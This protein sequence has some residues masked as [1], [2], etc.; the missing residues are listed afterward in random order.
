MR[1]LVALVLMS[2]LVALSLKGNANAQI[3][4][5]AQ[6]RFAESAVVE[7]LRFRQGDLASLM[8]SKRLFTAAGWADFVKRLAG[9]VDTQGAPSFTSSFV[10]S[11]S[12]IASTEDGDSRIVT[13][14]GVLKHEIRHPQGGAS[15]V[16]YRA[17]IDL[18][19]SPSPFKIELLQQRTCGGSR[20]MASCR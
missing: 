7:A 2:L 9:H 19:V 3:N 15:A 10:P 5:D 11:A 14:P 18:R 12:A 17:E 8:D 20:T 13:V 16:S 4:G 1:E 6:T